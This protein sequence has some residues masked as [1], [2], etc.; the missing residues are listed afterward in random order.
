MK[1]ASRYD[2]PNCAV[3]SNDV[4]VL[5]QTEINNALRSPGDRDPSREHI[6]RDAFSYDLT[7]RE[8]EFYEKMYVPAKAGVVGSDSYLQELF[9]AGRIDTLK[10]G[11]ADKDLLDFVRVDS[12]RLMALVA[13]VGWGK[14]VLLKHVWFYLLGQ[15][16]QLRA[17]VLPIYVSVD[18]EV[19]AFAEQK[20]DEEIV[21]CLH[22]RILQPRLT[23]IVRPFAQIDDEAFWRFLA[24]RTDDFA[25]L[26]YDEDALTKI[27]SVD[28]DHSRLVQRY[29]LRRQASKNRDF[30]Y[31]ATQYVVMACHKLPLLILDNVDPLPIAAHRA[32]LREAVRLSEVYG[33]RVIISMR[34]NTFDHLAGDPDG[35]IGAL[36]FVEVAMPQTNVREYL[37]RRVEG[38]L[39]EL[40]PSRRLRVEDER[41]KHLLFPADNP[42]E[43]ILALVE[44]LLTDDAAQVLDYI[45]YHN[46]RLLNAYLREYLSTGYVD[47][48]R[49]IWALA[50][51]VATESTHY[52]SPLWVLLSSVLTCNHETHFSNSGHKSARLLKAIVN[53]YC[54]GAHDVNP[55]SIRLHLLSFLERREETS[56][57]EIYD[58][59]SRLFETPPP[60]LETAITRALFRLLQGHLI[61][62]PR[63][64]RVSDESTVRGLDPMSITD[65]GSYYRR[66]LSTY[67]EY[68]AYMKDDVD[69]AANPRAIKD[70]VEE[71]HLQGRYEHICRFLQHLFDAEH[72]FLSVLTE[73]QRAYLNADFSCI[74]SGSPYTIHPAVSA[75]IHFGRLRGAKKAII[76]G[77][78]EL[79][80]RIETCG[81]AFRE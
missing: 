19:N 72:G 45:S 65:T 3:P 52:A 64:Y 23:R 79:M 6:G 53:L 51:K 8:R 74:E 47:K 70:C 63:S 24:D 44:A 40:D 30:A 26:G 10:I 39:T 58:A 17:T 81:A 25:D 61:E 12:P 11:E 33:L 5:Y 62:S 54:N 18:Q 59:Y 4:Y 37:T 68:L 77:Y 16:P 29:D 15:S 56:F 20:S 78:E 21:Q 34:K 43:M 48:H 66:T 69:L 46:L 2:P 80:G 32:I 28:G 38:A 14:T 9:P 49:M 67:F 42:R 73:E 36:D 13:P 35:V 41:G 75:M 76:E 7:D 55:H 71:K 27:N 22:E 1:L 57:H 31:C 60:G 50:D